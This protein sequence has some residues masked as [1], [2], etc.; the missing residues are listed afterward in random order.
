[1]RSG[2]ERHIESKAGFLRH[3]PM[4]D[5]SSL[6]MYVDVAAYYCVPR[7]VCFSHLYTLQTPVQILK[8]TLNA[9]PSNL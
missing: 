7:M 3:E 6:H 1:M 2:G 9:I 5:T 8:L 4:T